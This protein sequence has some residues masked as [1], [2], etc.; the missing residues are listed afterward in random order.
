MVYRDMEIGD[1]EFYIFLTFLLLLL[2]EKF[3]FFFSFVWVSFVQVGWSMDMKIVFTGFFLQVHILEAVFA[4]AIENYIGLVFYLFCS[5]FFVSPSK[6]KRKILG[7]ECLICLLWCALQPPN[8][9]NS[10][11]C[12]GRIF[13]FCFAFG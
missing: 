5:F 6:T 10:L 2:M 4:Y 11:K 1:G 12:F 9:D 13:F 3:E 7:L 8:Q